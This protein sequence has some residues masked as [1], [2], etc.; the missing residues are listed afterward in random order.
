MLEQPSNYLWVVCLK[1]RWPLPRF[2]EAIIGPFAQWTLVLIGGKVGTAA[3]IG[4]DSKRSKKLTNDQ[5]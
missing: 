3:Y 2:E 1:E 4:H 5:V